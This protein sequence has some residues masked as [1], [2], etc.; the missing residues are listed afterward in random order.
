LRLVGGAGVEVEDAAGEHVRRDDV[1]ARLA[2]DALP[3]QPQQG[4]SRLP[5]RLTGFAKRDGDAG[6]AVL[7]AL[8]E[9]LKAEID[10]R[11]RLDQQFTGYRRVWGTPRRPRRRLAL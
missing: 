8:Y 6:V 2:V 7:V 4:E 3:L 11:R 10:Q 9:P 5:R 1:D